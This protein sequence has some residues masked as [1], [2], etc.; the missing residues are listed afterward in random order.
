MT[1]GLWALKNLGPT[2]YRTLARRGAALAT[3]LA[4]AARAAGVPLQVNA[5]GSLLTPFFTSTPVRDYQSALVANTGAYATFFRGML[6][7]G[8]YP[9]PS[10][11]EAWFLSAAHTDTHIKKTIAAAREAMKEVRKIL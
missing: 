3:G 9:P 10:Q 8:V 7:R 6:K 2:L 4:D 11:F 5:F 1:A